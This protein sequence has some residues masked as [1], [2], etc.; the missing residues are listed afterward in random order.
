M[1]LSI[2][3]CA[4]RQ[5]RGPPVRAKERKIAASE[6]LDDDLALFY[7]ELVAEHYRRATCFLRK[8]SSEWRW[9][10]TYCCSS[11]L[12]E[13]VENT[14]EIVERCRGVFRIERC[15]LA[16]AL[17]WS[18]R[19]RQPLPI[20]IRNE[21]EHL[22]S[23][24]KWDTRLDRVSLRGWPFSL[25]DFRGSFFELFYDDSFIGGVLIDKY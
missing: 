7:T 12:G 10:S 5:A 16:L 25:D 3:D 22:E 17:I 24:T 11:F 18:L 19:Y 14:S 8:S 9:E 1:L 20:R 23:Y 2:V 21:R 15:W 4:Y 13:F 6:R